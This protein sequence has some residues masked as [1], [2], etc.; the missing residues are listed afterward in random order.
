MLHDDDMTGVVEV[1]VDDRARGRGYDRLT[2]GVRPVEIPVL[3]G[4]GE[5]GVVDRV[6][7]GIAVLD[8]E[9]LA[10]PLPLGDDRVGEG[11]RL[12]LRQHGLQPSKCET[13]ASSDDHCHV[14]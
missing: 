9:A 4:V 14:D 12:G 13:C 5:T 7:A 2:G 6:L 11:D 1:S 10:G 3:P 8:V